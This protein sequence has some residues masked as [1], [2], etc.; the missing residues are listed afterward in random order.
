MSRT[1]CGHC[2]GTGT[3]N[4]VAG[5]WRVWVCP[6]ITCQVCNGRGFL[7]G[8]KPYVTGYMERKARGYKV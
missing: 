6:S 4:Y 8:G 3:D 7:L 2:R 1:I 5:E